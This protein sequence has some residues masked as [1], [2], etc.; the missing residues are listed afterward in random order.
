[1]KK[2]MNIS[3]YLYKLLKYSLSMLNCL[4]LYKNFMCSNI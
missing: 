2:L 4:I 1:M 3:E